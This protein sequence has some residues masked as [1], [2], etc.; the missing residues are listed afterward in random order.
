MAL[1]VDL[2]FPDA[3]GLGALFETHRIEFFDG[4]SELFE[5]HLVAFSP[6]GDIEPRTLIG[7]P[8]TVH[9]RDEALLPAVSGIVRQA[10]RHSLE[11]TGTTQYELTVVPPEWLLTRARQTCIYQARSS[12]E[13]V[14]AVLERHGRRRSPPAGLPAVPRREYCVQYDEPDHDFVFRV[15][16]EDGIAALFDHQASRWILTDDTRSGALPAEEPIAHN[17]SNL[18]PGGPAV[19]RWTELWD[20][21]TSAITRRDYDF[22]KPRFTLQARAAVPAPATNEASLEDYAYDV[23]AFATDTEGAALVSRRLEA[24]RATARRLR[25]VTNFAVGAGARLTI[26]GPDIA[27]EWLVVASRSA[28]ESSAEGG[29]GRQHEV[30][31]IPADIPFRPRPW[32]K[33]RI[34]GTQTA[35]VVG[36][37]PPG[38]VDADE[39]GRVK[40]ELRWDRRD[41]GRGNP[42]RWV[43][44]AQAWAGPGYGLVTLPRVG[45]EVLLS[46]SEG[47]P[48]Q[49]LVIGRVHNAVNV[50]PLALPQ[51][52]GTKAIWKSQSFG[53]SGPVDGFN[54]ICMTDRAGEELL[55]ITA[56]LDE[57][58]RVGRDSTSIVGRH[59]ATWIKGDDQ[60]EIDGKQSITVHGSSQTAVKGTASSQGGAV[61]LSS[62]T[63]M[64][65][66]AKGNLTLITDSDRTDQTK[67]NHFVKAGSV[68]TDA[69][70]VV[71]VNAEHFHVFAR[72]SIKLVCGGSAIE[73]EPGG[74]RI[75]SSGPVSVNGGVVKLNCD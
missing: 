24:A 23:G 39:L 40:V 2:D 35:F 16:A 50:P 42:T 22:Q 48:D 62:R 69:G 54:M 28:L 18:T 47:D 14:A 3:A 71:Q 38:T 73:I 7:Q 6:S 12:P 57:A 32:Q 1:K 5:L 19:L 26:T 74:I 45:D 52:D 64:K 4:L 29:G 33:P 34:H 61:D 60:I 17:P 11:A 51:P 70:D 53:P 46:F 65:L 66:Y 21:E 43:R 41:L 56:Q 63:T 75:V 20:V 36:D 31:V 10:R 13:I 58:E 44:V 67:S 8:I 37:T 9:L 59:R 27:G 72:S 49:P 30:T 68:Y 15:L 25:L 55:E